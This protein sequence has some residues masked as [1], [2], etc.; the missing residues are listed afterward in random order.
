[1]Q[2]RL[3]ISDPTQRTNKAKGELTMT[4]TTLQVEDTGCERLFAALELSNKKWKLALA[5]RGKHREVNVG[6]GDVAAVLA[7]FEK[8]KARMGL[9]PNA[10]V[11]SCYEAGRDGFWLHRQLEQAGVENLVVDSSSIEVDRRQR[12][13]KTDRLDAWRLLRQLVRYQEGERQA[14]RVVRVP[15]EEAE[16][17]RRP[18]RELQRLR[19]ERTAH[20]NRIRALLVLHGIRV[21]LGQGFPDRVAQAQGRDGRPLPPAL[22]AELIREFVRWEVVNTQIGTLETERRVRLGQREP[23]DPAVRIS[24]QLAR[25][26][27]IGATSATVFAYEFFAW[28]DF[29][30]RRQVGAATGLVASP[31]ASGDRRTDQGISK[32]GNRRVRTT[33]IQ[34]AWGWLRYQPESTLTKW[35]KNRFAG[36]P[37]TRRIGIVALARRLI[38]NLWRY[39]QQGVI[40]DGGV[41][42]KATTA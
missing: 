18:H 25:L 40:P 28:R 4:Q 8:A 27:G 36:S 7:E 17:G 35:F 14:L 23:S 21:E 33:L 38:I 30:N 22:Q 1:M 39:V 6:G 9:D 13:A 2:D 15:S 26:C 31:Y 20:G 41:R 11:T 5:A 16:D 19:E 12:R 29:R 37:R 32:A 10:P 24:Q 3:V 42:F 34:I